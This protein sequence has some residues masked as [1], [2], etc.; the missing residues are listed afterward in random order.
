MK[1]FFGG[2]IIA[3]VAVIG[4]GASTHASVNDF[5]F[6]SFEA[7]Y[8][9]GADAEGRSTLKTVERLSAVFPDFDQNHGIERAIP[10]KYDG[11][12]V[13]LKIESVTDDT[14]KRLNY[15]TYAQGDYEVLRIGDEDRY[16]RGQKTYVIT[17]TQRD[18][19]KIFADK[20]LNE[21]YWDVNGTEWRQSF[22]SVTARV[23][24]SDA[25]LPTLKGE[26]ACYVGAAGSTDRCSLVR[27]GNVLTATQSDLKPGENV[28]VAI[29]FTLGTFRGYEPSFWDRLVGIWLVSLVVS[30][31]VGVIAII[32]LSIRYGRVSNR[33]KELEPIAPE[34]IPPAKWSIL[35]SSKIGQGTRADTTAQIID[36]AVRHYVT[37]AQ[38]KEKSLF[39]QAEY[40]LEII[41]PIEDLNSE[42]QKFVQTLFGSNKVGT[43]LQTKS[44][45]NNY[46]LSSKLQKNGTELTK[47]IKGTYGLRVKDETASR[48]FR[49]TSLILFIAGVVTISPLLLIA[50]LVAYIS[51]WQLR[52]LSDEGLGL[53]RYLAGL[54]MYIEAA[55]KDR[56]AMLQSPDG[57]AKTG[58]KVSGD[59]DKKLIALYE[60]VL[61]YAVL[62]GQEKEWNNRLAVMYE[63]AGAVPS[64]YVG[65]SAFSAAAFTGAMNDFS[66]SMN[67]YGASTS[68]SSSGSSGGG[69]SGGGGG[70]G[71]GGGW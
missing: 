22:G 69:S 6:T 16:V 50:A 24:V 70:G 64:W 20:S 67:S 28:T 27:D 37:I 33:T 46:T 11:H 48:P 30:S 21:F 19:T 26:N 62:F 10:K 13:G 25:L 55:E 7:D 4:L 3:I 57:A 1:R 42:E 66:G 41:K 47:T 43:K 63:D 65:H 36:L 51:A 5:T 29:G 40:E 59:D 60:R 56:I 8:Y 35:V 17:Y 31:I 32:W 61:P 12:P 53:R 38:T 34:Y 9:L 2:F 68:S 71:G 18:V 39:Q 15:S 52:P 44:L 23:H 54:K 58:V 45:K 49:T 14:G